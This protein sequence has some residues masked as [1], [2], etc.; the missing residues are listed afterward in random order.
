[1]LMPAA[2]SVGETWTW[3][4]AASGTATASIAPAARPAAR[5]VRRRAGEDMREEV[6]DGLS[7]GGATM[8]QVGAAP[9]ALA[10]PVVSRD[11]AVVR[12][13]MPLLRRGSERENGWAPA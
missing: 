4:D 2:L 12:Q 13:G 10:G 7:V 11:A 6:M 9:A 5:R 1:M 8:S 3:A